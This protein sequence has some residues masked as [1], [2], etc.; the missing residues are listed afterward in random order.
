MKKIIAN[1]IGFMILIMI[2][3]NVQAS[4]KI[5]ANIVSNVDEL[6]PGQEMT[7]TLKFDN[8]QEIKKGI[9][10]YKATLVYDKTIFEEIT[11]NN[12]EQLNQW[13]ELQYN[14]QNCTNK[15]KS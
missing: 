3:T 8:Y 5:N 12:F 10:A 1:L 7:L 11:F 9:N 13:E 2:T 14:K 15:V 4:S 6:K